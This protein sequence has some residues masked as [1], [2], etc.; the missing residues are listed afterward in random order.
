[1]QKAVVIGAGFAGM[2]AAA[3]LAQSNFEV[4]LIEQHSAPGGRCRTWKK[5]GFTFDMG[6]SWYWMP[7]VFERFYQRFHHSQ[8]DFYDLERLDPSYQVFFEDGAYSLPAS[9]EQLSQLFEKWETGAAH[10]LQLFLKDAAYKYEVGMREFV[11][12][13]SFSWIEFLDFRLISSL[14][15]MNLFSSLQSEVR[16]KFKDTRIR[17]IL[18]FPVLFLGAKPGNTPSLYSLMNYADIELGTWYPQGGMHQIAL[19]FEQIAKEQHVNFHYNEKLI[20]FEYSQNLINQVNTDQQS[21]ENVDLVVSGADYYHTEQLLPKQLRSYSDDY[22]Y[23]RKLSPSCLLYFLGVNK[24]IKGLE[25]H[26]LFFDEEF[27]QHA[28]EIYDQPQW[29]TKP[30]FY[31]CLPSKTD[32]TVA[33]QGSDNL[34][35]LLPIAPDLQENPNL[36]E[37]Y[38]NKMLERLE[39]HTNQSIREHI[40]VKRSF[41]VQDFKDTY[42]SFRGNAYGLANTLR[43]TAVLKPGMRS[44]NISNLYFCGQL[45]VPGPGVPPSIISG[46]VIADY[47]IKHHYG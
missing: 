24:K 30:L 43:Q 28:K 15:K 36:H 27:Q 17:K 9:T 19:A 40:V 10:Q 11:Y 14:F 38:L 16:S 26:N 5:D 20:G 44:K 35:L 22:W 8:T 37:S 33:P 39:F 21:I 4:H 7:D 12:K 23:S 42:N 13:P 32:P 45:T 41:G 29:P 1:M 3:V 34:F 31:A 46:Q 47:I 25:H 18:E 6:P 2:S